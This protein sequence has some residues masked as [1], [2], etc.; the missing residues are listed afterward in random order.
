MTLSVIEKIKAAGPDLLD[1][2]TITSKI[3][4]A[5]SISTSKNLL[6]VPRVI[7]LDDPGLSVVI[8]RRGSVITADIVPNSQEQILQLQKDELD[9][10]V[11]RALGPSGPTDIGSSSSSGSAE[12]LFQPQPINLFQGN[13]GLT[14]QPAVISDPVLFTPSNLILPPSPPAA[15]PLTNTPVIA[16]ESIN[17]VNATVAGTKIVNASAANAGFT[18]EG[19][20][21]G[22]DG[23]TVTL[24]IVDSQDQVVLTFV[25]TAAAGK[26][27]VT[28]TPAQA[29][30]LSDGDYTVTATITDS[31]GNLV[32]ASQPITVDQTPPTIAITTIANVGNNIINADVANSGFTISGTETGA[33]GQQVTVTILDSQGHVIGSYAT[34]A[35]S[36]FWLVN[37]SATAAQG[38]ADGNYTVS[39]IVSDAA[40]NPAAPSNANF[41]LDTTADADNNLVLSA[42]NA[43]GGVNAAAVSITLSGLDSDI[44]SGTITLSDGNGHTATHTLT[45]AEIAAGTVTLQ[46][47]DFSGFGTLNHADS[48]ITVSATVTDNAGN[49]ATPASDSFV[50]DTTAD[51]DNNLV[52]S[53]FNA[54]GGVNAA[55][56][57]ITLAGLDGDIVSGTITLSD[58]DGHTATHTLT[59]AEI[60]AGTVTLQAGDFSGFGTLNHADSLITVSATVTDNAGNTAAPSNANFTL[61]TTADADNNLVLSAFT[62]AGGVNASAVSITLS[63]LDGDIVS[64]TITLSDGNGHTATHTLTA[65][66]IAAGTVTLQAGDFSGFGT[67]NH[68]DSLITVSATV[69]DNA[70]NPAAP[71]NANFTLD[72][73]ADADNNLVLSAFTAAGGVNASA[74]SITLSGL[75]GDIVSGTITLSDGNGHTATHT[76]TAAEIAAGTVTLQA[77]DFSG[78]GTLNHADSLITVSAT[79]TDN[80]GNHG[81]AEQ[82]ELH[83]RHHGGRRQQ[84]GAERV[85]RGRRR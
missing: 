56:V 36:G 23:Q 52:L 72:T 55:A 14:P 82:C 25:A 84:P 77:G 51:A 34:T 43:A 62:A 31:T 28:V 46:A 19:T 59:A 22:A 32:Q 11:I 45:A 13:G 4:P 5:P 49:P 3:S 12:I 79:V 20:E 73:T 83:A 60:A 65:A 57:S 9:V 66:E 30:A 63:G 67:L 48:L 10:R 18:I 26:W 81:G 85:Q 21:T 15:P 1:N 24:T 71:S 33:D 2:D 7:V 74:V 50:L 17:T 27:L 70:G 75:D 61:D 16:I 80:A 39:V 37:V 47:G 68:A 54:A 69:T 29:T 35:G 44:V 6:P 8:A 76:L 53:A 64:G 40:G 42:F 41:T 58:G 78:F 38:L